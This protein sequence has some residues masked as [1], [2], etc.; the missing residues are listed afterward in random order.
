M[1]SV[2]I[3]SA[4]FK[5]AAQ[6]FPICIEVERSSVKGMLLVTTDALELDLPA[7]ELQLGEPSND[8][9]ELEALF[10]KLT[11]EIT[12]RGY[13]LASTRGNA[14]WSATL[15]K[16]PPPLVSLPDTLMPAVF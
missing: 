4:M 13:T 10:G 9:A 5:N 1:P 11:A 3:F 8:P 2:E 12:G 6:P 15:N 16:A 14:N 7:H